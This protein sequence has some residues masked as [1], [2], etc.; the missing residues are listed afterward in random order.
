M[1][2]FR[3]NIVAIAI[4]IELE[5]ASVI[6]IILLQAKMRF[7]L[8]NPINFLNIIILYDIDDGMKVNLRR[9]HIC[10]KCP[11]LN[12]QLRVEYYESIATTESYQ[13]TVDFYRPR[14]VGTF[15]KST[16]NC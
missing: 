12:L 15:Q 16:T 7:F 6:N 3:S 1:R 9:L 14:A 8:Q 4:R 13:L 11:S 10:R 2:L 5:I